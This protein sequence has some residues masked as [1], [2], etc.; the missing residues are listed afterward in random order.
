[1]WADSGPTA[2]ASGRTGIRAIAAIP[3]L[4]G[5]SFTARNGSSFLLSVRIAIG[6]A[7]TSAALASAIHGLSANAFFITLL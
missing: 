5:N 1:M 2:V 3:L 7:S 6:E 4:A